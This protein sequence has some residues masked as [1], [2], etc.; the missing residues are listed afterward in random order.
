MIFFQ[1]IIPSV[2]TPDLTVKIMKIFEQG[3][4]NRESNYYCIN[5]LCKEFE[6][7]EMLLIQSRLVDEM[8]LNRCIKNVVFEGNKLLNDAIN[9]CSFDL[10]EMDF[11]KIKFHECFELFLQT[12]LN[13]NCVS[14]IFIQKKNYFNIT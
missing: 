11:V 5:I 4:L 3:D 1:D 13:C 6:R 12:I 14:S 8:I 7:I 9:H 2:I 10:V